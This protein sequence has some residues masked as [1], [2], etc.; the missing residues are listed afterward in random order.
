MLRPV[1]GTD[2]RVRALPDGEQ[3]DE[4]LSTPVRTAQP[5]CVE[6]D[7]FVQGETL[8]D[9]SEGHRNNLERGS[10]E[11]ARLKADFEG[12]SSSEQV[13]RLEIFSRS[14]CALRL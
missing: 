14:S 13:L 7:P 3:T 2:H 10:R 12:G 1:D 8:E 11:L 6:A 4:R 5:L 9:K